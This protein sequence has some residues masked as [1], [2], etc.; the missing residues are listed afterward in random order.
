MRSNRRRG[1]GS[2]VSSTSCWRHSC[3]QSRCR[4]CARCSHRTDTHPI[5]DAAGF[6]LFLG[7]AMLC[8]LLYTLLVTIPCIGN[9]MSRQPDVLLALGWLIYGVG[10]TGIE[11]VVLV[12]IFRGP[13]GE[14][15][16]FLLA[17]NICQCA[18]V[19]GTL[20]ESS[21]PSVFGSCGQARRKKARGPGAHG[22]NV[23]QVVE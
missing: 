1:P 10:L 15:L 2:S 13:P 20:P 16:L 6:L 17:V 14:V 5:R 9:M 3:W 21:G 7:A 19:F 23:R 12:A 18:T 22:G 8:I 4:R 11:I